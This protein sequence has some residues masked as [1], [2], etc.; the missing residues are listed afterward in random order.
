MFAQFDQ[1]ITVGAGEDIAAVGKPFAF[2]QYPVFLGVSHPLWR[3]HGSEVENWVHGGQIAG[4]L[5]A[6]G[7][8]QHIVVSSSC[9][10]RELVDDLNCFRE[11]LVPIS[12][13]HRREIAVHR[14]GEIPVEGVLRHQIHGNG[15]D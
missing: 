10:G 2:A 15:Q 7:V 6:V 13:L 9:G 11:P 8:L 14:I 12:F 4:E 5:H 1:L 3:R